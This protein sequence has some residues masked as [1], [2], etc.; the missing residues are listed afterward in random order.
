MNLIDSDMCTF[1]NNEPETIS[2]LLWDC[3]CVQD[4]YNDVRYRLQSSSIVFNFSYKKFI[5]GPYYNDPEST[6]LLTLKYFIYQCKCKKE[7]LSMIHFL[8]TVKNMYEIYK[9]YFR[10]IEKPEFFMLKWSSLEKF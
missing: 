1:C 5:L 9:E 4:F 6:F 8:A 2:H 7:D 10:R 3:Q